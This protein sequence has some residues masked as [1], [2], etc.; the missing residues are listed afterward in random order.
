M[1]FSCEKAILSAAISTASRAVAPKSAVPAL[2]G[3][4]VEA[5][6]D[7]KLT[8][9]NLETGIRTRLDADITE[10]GVAVLPARLFGEIIRKLPDDVVTVTCSEDG[11]AKIDCGMSSFTIVGISPEDFPELPTVEGKQGFTVEQN[12]L[13]SM[14]SQT[15]FA[16]STNESKPVHTGSLFEVEGEQ[17]TV[18]SV[19]GYRLALRREKIHPQEEGA[20]FSFV[21]PGAALREVERVSQDLEE[22]L[23]VTLGARHIL[24]EVGDTVLISRLL[25]GEFINYRNAVPKT[26]KYVLTA[27]VKQLVAGVERV[28]LLIS[29]KLKNPVR[30]RIEDGVVRLSCIAAV[31]RAYDECPIM[32]NGEGLEI[33]FNNRYLLEALKAVDDEQVVLELNS[34]ES[35]CN[36]RPLEG[37]KYLFMV[38]PVRLRAGV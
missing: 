18:V 21:V 14:I 15:I 32:G 25:E 13:K 24:F 3:I 29:E 23:N 28:S 4:L 7:L 17:L 31:G 36:I 1:K 16:V 2:E 12:V 8:G 37:E 34:G 26:A 33:G 10:P 38:L 22:L 6:S 19:D 20:S 5:G 35:P 30:C 9:Y 11:S 27:D